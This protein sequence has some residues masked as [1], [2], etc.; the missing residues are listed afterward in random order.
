MKKKVKPKRSYNG[1]Y[2]RVDRH[3]VSTSAGSRR[4][5]EVQI[6]AEHFGSWQ[7]GTDARFGIRSS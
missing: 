7:L 6:P 1:D 3:S 4:G 5:E 2:R